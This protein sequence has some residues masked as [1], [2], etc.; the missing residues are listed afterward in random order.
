M[1]P[2]YLI[3]HHS[4]TDR[5]TTT[6]ASVKA[7]HISKGWG[8]IGYHYFIT[9][10][11]CHSGR[12]EDVVGAHCIADGMNF[13][14]LGICLAGNFEN[15]T[16]TDWQVNRLKQLIK[17]LQNK[18]NIPNKNILAHRE[19]SGAATACCGKNLLP[20]IIEI[21]GEI[22]NADEIAVK[23]SVFEALVSASSRY[24]EF[25]KAGY[26]SATEVKQLVSE[27]RKSIDDKQATI[28]SEKERAETIRQDF[29]D[30]VAMVAISLGTVQEVPQIKVRLD[31]IE[32][33]LD[34][35][36]DIQVAFANL[37]LS[38][39]KEK[40]ELNAEIAR[41]KAMLAN[42]DVLENAKLDELLRE[43]VQ[44]LLKI[45]KRR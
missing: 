6:F 9:P 45:I 7:Y 25:T 18:Y 17:E 28:N 10:S 34:D 15:E 42:K 40:E 32:K 22:M 35:L 39:G 38:A 5:D 31:E 23:K 11:M 21:R 19:V 41:L 29:N 27:M 14:S 37:E 24:D 36:S 13:K 16:P 33:D 2:S 30:F 43:I 1:T 20:I 26:G 12:G 4:A 8:D 3:I 44:R